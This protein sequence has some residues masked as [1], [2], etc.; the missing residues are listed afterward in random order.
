MSEKMNQPWDT[1][2][3]EEPQHNFLPTLVWYVASTEADC[4]CPNTINYIVAPNVNTTP[5]AH[6][7]VINDPVINIHFGRRE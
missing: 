6:P 2:E 5:P 3:T 7:G 1:S 4:R